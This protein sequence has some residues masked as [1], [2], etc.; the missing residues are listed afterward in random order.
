MGKRVIFGLLYGASM[1]GLF[2]W[3]DQYAPLVLAGFTLLLL[4]ETAKMVALDTRALLLALASVSLA[5]FGLN[6]WGE[7][8][9]LIASSITFAVLLAF[10]ALRSSRP[11]LNVR[12]G[13]FTVAYI[14]TP[15]VFLVQES[16]TNSNV[17]LFALFLIWSS[18]TLA[19][20][21]GRAF[22]KRA[23]APELSPKKTI[24]GAIGGV[25]GTLIVAYFLNPYT[26]DVSTAHGLA[27]GLAVSICAPL[28]DLV[29][30]ALKREAG[31]KDSGIFLPGH[32]G[33]LDR[34][35]SF[36]IAAPVALLI[37][38]YWLW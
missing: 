37:H 19:Y 5:V 2:G 23:L 14:W 10:A 9:V 26:A 8:Q 3:A 33:A 17:L 27:I 30:S 29:A 28:G 22:G 4:N 32:G 31:I 15:M 21:A 6:G 16:S 34:L 36:I 1:I 38:S 7:P 13:L 11:G 12:N 35:D 20:F 18:D 25:A 24:E